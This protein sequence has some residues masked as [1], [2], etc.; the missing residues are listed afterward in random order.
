MELLS[1]E[2]L[3][4]PLHFPDVLEPGLVASAGLGLSP[5]FPLLALPFHVIYG[6]HDVLRFPEALV[7]FS[8]IPFSL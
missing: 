2:A 7:V 6:F 5:S 8:F 4:L 1:Q 3:L